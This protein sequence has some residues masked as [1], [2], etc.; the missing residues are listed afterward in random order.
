MRRAHGQLVPAFAER[1]LQHHRGGQG[2]GFVGVAG[3]RVHHQ[4]AEHTHSHH[5]IESQNG[6]PTAGVNRRDDEGGRD[7]SQ[8]VP[9]AA[10]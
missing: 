2:A 4:R 3:Q 9:V 5:D 10:T 7:G 8:K 1:L 6:R